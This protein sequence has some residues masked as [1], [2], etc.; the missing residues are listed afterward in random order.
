MTL[1]KWNDLGKY[2]LSEDINF[3]FLIKLHIK[4]EEGKFNELSDDWDA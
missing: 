3:I 4:L 2:L 1:H